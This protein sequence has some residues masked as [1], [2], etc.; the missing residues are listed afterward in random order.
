[1]HIYRHHCIATTIESTTQQSTRHPLGHHSPK[2]TNKETIAPNPNDHNQPPRSLLRQRPR[3]LHSTNSTPCLDHHFAITQQHHHHHHADTNR[4]PPR[5][6]P[7]QQQPHPIPP[8][9]PHALDRRPPERRRDFR[10]RRS[11]QPAH[12]RRHHNRDGASQPEGAAEFVRRAFTRSV[13]DLYFPEPSLIQFAS[14]SKTI[15]NSETA[16]ERTWS[17][18]RHLLTIGFFRN[19][20][21]A[22]GF[23]RRVSTRVLAQGSSDKYKA[24]KMPRGDY[25]RYFKHDA[26]GAYVGTEPEREWDEEE[27]MAKYGQYQHLPLR[28]VVGG[29]RTTTANDVIPT[30]WGT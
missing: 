7:K 10:A 14:V 24:V 4:D 2:S 11:R 25:S 17:E 9:S 28:S 1:M 30:G 21:P 5:L 15:R 12:R 18:T 19:R 13:S 16:R 6:N 3:A 20:P 8:R 23:F 27:I 26:Q 29:G 22:R